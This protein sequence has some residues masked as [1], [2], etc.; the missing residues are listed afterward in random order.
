MEVL[1]MATRNGPKPLEKMTPVEKISSIA[2]D[3][4]LHISDAIGIARTAQERHIDEQEADCKAALGLIL[5]RLEQIQEGHSLIVKH[6]P[7]R[8]HTPA[9]EGRQA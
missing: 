6:A 1:T 3:M 4:E 2:Y 7:Y 9:E 8:N 5:F